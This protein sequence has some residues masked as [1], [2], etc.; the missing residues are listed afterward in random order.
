MMKR[1][2]VFFMFL[3]GFSYGQTNNFV[4]ENLDINNENPHFGLMRVG[5]NI[6]LTSFELDR[7]GK[8]KRVHGEPKLMVLQGYLVGNDKIENL[9]PLQIDPKADVSKINSATLSADGK[10][11]YISTVYTKKNKPKVP[12]KETNFHIE[13]GE[14]ESGVGFTNFKVLDFCKPRFSYAHP[15]L[16]SDG[17]TMYFT[18]NIK[19][20]KNTSKGASDIYKVDILED[21]TYSEPLNLGLKVN[22]YSKEMFPYIADDNT[23]YFSSNRP[24]GFGGYDLYKSTMNS[25]GAFE[26][27]VK[28]EEPLNSNKDDLS[29]IINADN[30]SGFLSSKRLGGK[31]D[32]DVYFFKKM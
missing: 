30:V 16:S 2:A 9:M 12:F 17:K 22:S 21:G 8:V 13:V 11:I 23:L 31:G 24:N 14:F 32:D 10:K 6:M 29:I 25:E 20:G 15:A 26:K 7:K 28:L 1:I 27:A 3:C 19:G 18:A 4:I 5:N